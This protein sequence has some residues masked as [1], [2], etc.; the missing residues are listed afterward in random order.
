[1]IHDSAN[2][3][4]NSILIGIHLSIEITVNPRNW[5]FPSNF[6]YKCIP[7]QNGLHIPLRI[8]NW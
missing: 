1:M 6:L 8:I 5:I 2:Q 3:I 7:R 4:R